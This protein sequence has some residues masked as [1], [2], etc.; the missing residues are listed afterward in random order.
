MA[1]RDGQSLTG[2]SVD[3]AVLF[4]DGTVCMASAES[5][6]IGFRDSDAAC[7]FGRSTRRSVNRAAPNTQQK[8]PTMTYTNENENSKPR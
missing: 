8:K 1:W 5:K 2:C 6:C 4:S 3:D 7:A